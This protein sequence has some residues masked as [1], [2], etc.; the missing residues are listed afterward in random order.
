[1]APCPQRSSPSPLD[2]AYDTRASVM[3]M[4][5]AG[6]IMKHERLIFLQALSEVFTFPCRDILFIHWSHMEWH[7]DIAIISFTEMPIEKVRLFGSVSTAASSGTPLEAGV[8]LGWQAHALNKVGK[9][10]PQ[11]ECSEILVPTR[12]FL[13]LLCQEKPASASLQDV[14]WRR[15]NLMASDYLT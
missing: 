2:D 9:A 13:P 15:D 6:V 14:W 3:R 11:R 7:V 1:M 12:V 4:I 10:H 5:Q 8:K